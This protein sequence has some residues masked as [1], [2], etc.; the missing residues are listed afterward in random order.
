[1]GGR[2]MVS[3]A[4]LEAIVAKRLKERAD[5]IAEVKAALKPEL[6]QMSDRIDD[7]NHVKQVMTSQ[8]REL[9][10]ELKGELVELNAAVRLS[11]RRI[12]EHARLNAHPGDPAVEAIKDLGLPGLSLEEK[13]ALPAVLEQHVRTQDDRAEID[14]RHIDRRAWLHLVLT[15]GATLIGAAVGAVTIAAAF[16]IKAHP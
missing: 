11:Q 14:R 6:E 7:S 15:F 13:K 12:E 16:G 5:V 2:R 4:E 3:E 10:D 1:M 9:K 8:I